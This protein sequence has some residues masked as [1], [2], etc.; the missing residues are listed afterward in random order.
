[1]S[2]TGDRGFLATVGQAPNKKSKTFLLSVFEFP[3]LYDFVVSPE[4]QLSR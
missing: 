3:L 4:L 2:G 1:M